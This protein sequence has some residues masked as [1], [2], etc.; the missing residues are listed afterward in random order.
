MRPFIS[1]RSSTVLVSKDGYDSRALELP[2]NLYR[3]VKYSTL[4]QPASWWN[5]DKVVVFTVM[6]YFNIKLLDR[7]SCSNKLNK[8][9]KMFLLLLICI[10]FP[11]STYLSSLFS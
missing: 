11:P 8:M 3:C 1:T 4:T 6:A 7:L 2:E 9:F 5:E 10:S